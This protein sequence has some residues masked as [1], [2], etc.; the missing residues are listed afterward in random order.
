MPFLAFF[1]LIAV[2]MKPTSLE[3]KDQAL[4]PLK[5]HH[6]NVKYLVTD[7]KNPLLHLNRHVFIYILHIHN[8]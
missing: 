6:E 4:V 1:V 8:K 5:I 2:R 3:L 7:D